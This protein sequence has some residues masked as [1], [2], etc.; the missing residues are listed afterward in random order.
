MAIYNND[1]D[2]N[3]EMWEKQNSKEPK[4]LLIDKAVFLDWYFDEDIRED[5]F[6]NQDVLRCLIED[7][8]FT[9]TAEAVLDGCGFIP[10]WV[11]AESQR[12]SVVLEKDSDDVDTSY[13]DEIKFA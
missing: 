6:N 13:Y 7:G 1:R 10:S 9:L 11:V 4:V 5:F 3:D 2:P 12:A 8:W